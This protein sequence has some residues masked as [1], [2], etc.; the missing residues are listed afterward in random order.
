MNAETEQLG[1]VRGPASVYMALCVPN[2]KLYFGITVSSLKRRMQ[3]HVSHARRESTYKFHRSI[4]KYGPTNFVWYEIGQVPTWKDACEVERALIQYFDTTNIGLNTTE[5]GEGSLGRHHT[6]ESKQKLSV[7]VSRTMTTEHRTRLAS[8]KLGNK[9]SLR[10]RVKMSD[11]HVG[12]TRTLES[13]SKMSA[14]KTK[15]SEEFKAEV[16]VYAQVHGFHAAS[17]KFGLPRRTISRW[18]WSPERHDTERLKILARAKAKDAANRARL[19][20]EY[21][22]C[23][24]S[25]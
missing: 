17:R 3:R 19:L 13:R 15:Y 14:A 5:G 20:A 25:T 9:A 21:S 2:N 1:R 6:K 10:T 18:M 23:A 24:A 12:Q 11:A 7:S 22:S 4:Y 16:L 8:L